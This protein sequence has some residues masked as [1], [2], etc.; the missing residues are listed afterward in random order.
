[1]VG[2]P[3]PPAQPQPPPADNAD[4]IFTL[5]VGKKA[6]VAGRRQGRRA[7]PTPPPPH[8]PSGP[9]G[10]LDADLDLGDAAETPAP[11]R[12]QA[13]GA[14]RTNAFGVEDAS[15]PK[16]PQGPSRQTSSVNRQAVAAGTSTST[17]TTPMSPAEPT[18]AQGG[19]RFMGI[20]RRKAVQQE[21]RNRAGAPLTLEERNRLRHEEMEREADVLDIQE[22]EDD[23]GE[24][25]TRKVAEPPKAAGQRVDGMDE[26]RDETGLILPDTGNEA[27]DLTQLTQ[28]LTPIGL[29]YEE[30]MDEVWDHNL[31]LTQ[32]SSDINA[33]REALAR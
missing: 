28:V 32:L 8:V 16:K 20:S 5:N 13:I 18:P 30:D 27:I 12:P 15:E 6:P 26:L 10:A 19:P 2:G 23:G 14:S 4:D 25:I 22:L 21:S 11:K 33:E 1:M 31:L 17:S 9:I 29:V 3:R 7:G 24:D